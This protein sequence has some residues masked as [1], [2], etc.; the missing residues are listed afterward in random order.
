MS[1]IKVVT[2]EVSRLATSLDVLAGRFE[3]VAQK[4][5]GYG[6]YAD[7]HAMEAGLNE[8]FGKWTDGMD[9]LHKQLTHLATQLHSAASSYDAAEGEIQN[10]ARTTQ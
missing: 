2:D 5:V 6:G 1:S 10:A 8:F 7:A 3:G 4:R 9:R